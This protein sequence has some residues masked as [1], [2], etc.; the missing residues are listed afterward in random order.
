M[1]LAAFVACILIVSCAELVDLENGQ[2]GDTGV[3]GV[4]ED[5]AGADSG[6]KQLDPGAEQVAARK[7]AT[8]ASDNASELARS[9]WPSPPPTA[10]PASIYR[11]A[12][13]DSFELTWTDTGDRDDVRLVGINAPE[14][15]AC[16]GAASKTEL[17]DLTEGSELM[18]QEEGFDEFG[19]VLANVWVDGV[20]L[21]GS[22]VRAGAVLA[23]AGAERFRTELA[24]A[25]R[26]ARTEELGLWS[27]D[28]CA[29]RDVNLVITWIESDPS[30]RDSEALEEEWIAIENTGVTEIDLSGWSVR[31]ESTR[32]RYFFGSGYTLSAGGSVKLRSGFGTD[33]ATDLYWQSTVPIW[34]NAGDT[35]FVLDPDGRF[36]T[37]RSYSTSE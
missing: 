9:A 12:D 7:P 18:V 1:M 23:S 28:T 25:Q 6:S 11:L 10:R 15:D 3:A 33:S 36:V 14:S 16:H 2:I 31:D 4:T 29:R 35:G 22:L 17:S 20:W 8:D 24:G 30:G 13:G 21:N 32:N 34:N 37:Y 5:L 26:A 27:T 19:R